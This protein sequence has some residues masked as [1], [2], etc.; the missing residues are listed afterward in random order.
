MNIR[1]C[2]L[3]SLI[4]V[5]IIHTSADLGSLAKDV[6]GRGIADL[7][8]D[9][10]KKHISTIDGFWD[11][12]IDYFASVDVSGMKIYQDGLVADGE[13]G[14]RIVEDCVKAGSRN[15]EL[16][17]GLLKK[18]AVLQKTEDL[19]LVIEERDRLLSITKARSNLL[20]IIA[21]VKYKFAKVRLLRKRDEFIADR[22]NETL[23]T[24]QK[25]ILF[26]GAY[27]NIK[28]KLNSDIQLEE[29]KDAR[30]I[31]Q[32]QRLFLYR[33]KHKAIFEELSRYLVSKVEP[34]Q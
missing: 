9:V 15:Y 1:G 6:A 3:R 16:V 29:I 25:G 4:I 18:G 2:K 34:R 12:I 20:R 14:Q 32:Y 13:L 33:N 26:I 22:I 27:H 10:W 11:E 21:F 30:K 19:K 5:P 28:D 7:G 24:E 17:S 23:K 8:E 31:R